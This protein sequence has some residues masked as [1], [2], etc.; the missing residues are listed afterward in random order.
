[1]TEAQKRLEELLRAVEKGDEVTICRRGVP[2]VDMV[3]T[4]KA[5]EKRPKL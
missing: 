2:V 4:R 1:M 3:L 5:K